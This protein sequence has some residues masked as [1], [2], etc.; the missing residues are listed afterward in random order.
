LIQHLRRWFV[1]T[2]AITPQSFASL[3]SLGVI[4]S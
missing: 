2:F 4:R 1:S 3:S